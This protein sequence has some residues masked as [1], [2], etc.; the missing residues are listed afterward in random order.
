MSRDD[1]P[2]SPSP[3][4]TQT[5][6]CSAPIDVMHVENWVFDL[7]NTLYR[8]HGEFFTQIV[9]NITKYISRYL[10]M[11]L[12]EARILQKQYLREYGTS[13]SGMMAVHGM[14]PADFLDYVHDVDLASLKPNPEL[15]KG[16]ERLPG[17]KFIYTNGSRGH[18]KNIAGHLGIWDLFDGVFAIEDG[19]YIAKPKPQPYAK[20]I[21]EFDINPHTAL[22]AEDS[23]LNL[24]VPRALGMQTLLVAPPQMGTPEYVDYQT[25]DLPK[26]LLDL[27]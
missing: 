6:P 27:S 4:S 23:P 11:H 13:L 18:A 19:D 8:A 12:T 10:A 25:N 3:L 1:T 21:K 14:D 26:W 24:E 22:M 20:F 2:Q 7:D 17:R 16:L 9:D 5:S 15:Y